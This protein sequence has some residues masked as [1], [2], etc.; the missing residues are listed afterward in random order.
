MRGGRRELSLKST[1]M[2]KGFDNE[3]RQWGWDQLKKAKEII[4]EQNKTIKSQRS[5]LNLLFSIIE[6]KNDK[7]SN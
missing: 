1:T 2:A 3:T 7:S 6:F 4:K 5:L